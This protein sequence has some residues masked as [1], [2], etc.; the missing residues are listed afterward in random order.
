VVGVVLSSENSKNSTTR[1]PQY[2]PDC[3]AEAVRKADGNLT[4]A[5]EMIGCHRTTVQKYC[6]EFEVCRKAKHDAR[7]EIVDLARTS[8]KERI[9]DG[10]TKAIQIAVRNYDHDTEPDKKEIDHT[11]SDDSLSPGADKET[12]KKALQELDTGNES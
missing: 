7:N 2:D 10:D 12:I 4:A 5:A 11:S 6:K 3:V 8:L 1:N 9:K